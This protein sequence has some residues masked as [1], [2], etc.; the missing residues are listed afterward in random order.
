MKKKPALIIAGCVFAVVSAAHWVR[1][2]QADE[3]IVAG[4]VVPV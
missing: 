4:Y 2:F 1:Y 3:V